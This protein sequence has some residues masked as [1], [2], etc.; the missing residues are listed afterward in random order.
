MPGR[1]KQRHVLVPDQAE[2]NR[3]YNKGRFGRPQS[4][5]ALKLTLAEAAFLVENDRLE[6]RAEGE[7]AV[8]L[9]RLVALAAAREPGF[10]VEFL[11]FRD[12]RERGYVLTPAAAADRDRE[13]HWVGYG[14]GDKP[15]SSEPSLRITVWSERTPARIDRLRALA[16]AGAADGVENLVALVD[17][18][19]DLTYYDL[20][21]EE[22]HGDT[23]DTDAV[24]ATAIFLRDRCLVD[25]AA[26]AKALHRHGFYGK[27][28]AGGLQLSLV[29]T[30]HLMRTAGLHVAA[31][32]E[33][34]ALDEEGFL[35]RA[36]QVDADVAQRLLVYADLRARG[37]TVKTGFKFGTHFRAYKQNPRGHHAPYLIH[38]VSRGFESGWPQVSRAVRLSHSVRKT[39]LFGVLDGDRV[40]YVRLARA[41]P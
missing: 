27:P 39:F 30:L 38:V 7:G 22:P 6:V 4:G 2:A 11:V 20:G 10:E 12:L 37:L 5:G 40:S 17:E 19:S 3:L 18:E 8:P 15:E 1:L 29:E 41:R 21:V 16:D 25:D 26:S 34:D 32:A 36:R 33:G 35:A 28:V 9:A 13:V 31:S 23:P 14:R 24:D